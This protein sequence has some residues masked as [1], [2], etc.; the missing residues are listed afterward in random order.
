MAAAAAATPAQNFVLLPLPLLQSR[1]NEEK[2]GCTDFSIS[3]ALE[4]NMCPNF[5][6]ILIQSKFL[7]QLF[8]ATIAI[9]SNKLNVIL[10]RQIR[11]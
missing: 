4:E 6:E 3:S 8:L 9:L 1:L 5:S 7:F 11:F 2:G 10:K